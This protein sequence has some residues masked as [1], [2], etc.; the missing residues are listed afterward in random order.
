M[1]EE[2]KVTSYEEFMAEYERRQKR[3][4][5]Q[6][7][8][9]QTFEI[10]VMAPGDFVMVM[11]TLMVQKLMPELVNTPGELAEPD[12]QKVMELMNNDEFLTSIKNIVC[13]GVISVNL[14]NKP[15]EECDKA[16]QELPIDILDTTTLLELNMAIRKASVPEDDSDQVRLFRVESAEADAGDGAGAPDS[17]GV[18]DPAVGDPVSGNGES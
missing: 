15:P 16:K 11:N 9:G 14:V 3:T 2:K 5:V 4:I 6:T 7:S 17:E 1:A 8:S 13:E 10:K 12:E 18:R